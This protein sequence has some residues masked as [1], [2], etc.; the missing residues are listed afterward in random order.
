MALSGDDVLALLNVSSVNNDIIFLM[1]LLTLVVVVVTL[2]MRLAEALEVVV[3]VV[4]IS[5]F[6]F[7]L[8]FTL[9]VSTV[10]MRNYMRI[11]TN[12]CRAVVDLLRGFLAVLS[13]NILAL[14][15]IGCVN[16]N[17]ILLMASLIIVSLARSV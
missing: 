5:R 1:A 8:S 16:D 15:D 3:V 2:L 7:S 10:S 12:I 9:M 13:H 11:M 6:S 17:I 14:L 4:S